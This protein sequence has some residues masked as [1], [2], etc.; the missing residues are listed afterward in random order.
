MVVVGAGHALPTIVSSWSSS[1]SSPDVPSLVVV[2]VVVIV[3]IV[4]SGPRCL[5]TTQPPHEQRLVAVAGVAP[6]RR[7]LLKN[8]LDVFFVS[9]EK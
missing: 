8:Y 9:D 5:A 7:C 2:I 6:F 3:V 4:F 1:S